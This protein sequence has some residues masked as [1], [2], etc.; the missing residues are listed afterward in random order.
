ML[1]REIELTD[2]ER[3]RCRVL[4]EYAQQWSIQRP[5]ILG[6]IKAYVLT[7]VGYGAPTTSLSETFQQRAFISMIEFRDYPTWLRDQKILTFLDHVRQNQHQKV[8]HNVNNYLKV[9][10][11]LLFLERNMKTTIYH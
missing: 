2:G 11:L 6:E 10:Q 3:A 4:A 1:K 8:R 7:D 9:H 5:Q